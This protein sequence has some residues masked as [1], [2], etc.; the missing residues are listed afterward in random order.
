MI[1][2]APAGDQ[3]SDMLR[4]VRSR[5]FAEL[6]TAELPFVWTVLRRL[7]VP[8]DQVEDAAHDVFVVVHRQLDDFEGRSSERTW[9]YAIA[10]RIA[11]RHRRSLRRRARRH[12]AL[13]TLASARAE[14]EQHEGLRRREATALLHA[15]L[16]SL[17][18]PK[19]EAFVLGELERLPRVSL[20]RALGVSPGTAYSRLR[21]ARADFDEAFGPEGPRGVVVR[22]LARRTQNPPPVAR[23][24][25]WLA[26]PGV[27]LSRALLAK[28]AVGVAAGVTVIGAFTVTG[29]EPEPAAITR[30]PATVEASPTHARTHAQRAPAE[31]AEPPPAETVATAPVRSPPP[32]ISTRRTPSR[33]EPVAAERPLLAEPPPAPVDALTEEALVMGRARTAMRA[34]RWDEAWSELRRHAERF[35]EGRLITERELSAITV[36]CHRGHDA[37]ALARARALLPRAS[38]QTKVSLRRSCVGDRLPWDESPITP[39]R[40]GDQSG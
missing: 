4:T 22:R 10:R 35:P 36:A 6:Y 29:A 8:Q 13:A 18:R 32:P 17:D 15:F 14:P 23:A 31:V 9:L 12:A 33:P 40:S 26:L 30:V 28:V 39:E 34:Q 3:D 20:G 21:A 11:W 1:N 37:H 7:G 38:S 25:V 16:E 19:R 5:R 27:G 2:P 24:R